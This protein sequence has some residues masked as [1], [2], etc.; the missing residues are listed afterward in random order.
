[1]T[2]YNEH[3]AF[4]V[5]KHMRPFLKHRGMS[6]V[7]GKLDESRAKFVTQLNHLG[8]YH[9][10]AK[11]SEDKL[12]SIIILAP[13]S[14]YVEKGPQ[15]RKLLSETSLLTDKNLEEVIIIA[16]E[17]ALR[18]KNLT[19]VI[20]EFRKG[21]SDKAKAEYYN[22]Y[23]YHVFSLEIPKAQI[24]PAH[25]IADDGEVKKFL[26]REKRTL[27]DL[28]RIAASSPPVI[29]IGARPGQVVRVDAPSE[30]AGYSVNYLLVSKA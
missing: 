25:H 30:T 11:T 27:V 22:M 10:D 16:P 24:V 17:S 28:R 20:L 6:L 26:D 7:K 13:Q 23:P 29:W 19:D 3:P 18:K 14:P 5:Y 1:M 21:T 4:L 8:H 9:L 15:L 2:S 12:V